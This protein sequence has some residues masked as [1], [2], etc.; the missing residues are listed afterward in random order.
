MNA[1]PV[2]E[3]KRTHH[4]FNTN[5][6]RALTLGLRP[7]CGR[8]VFE[9]DV[10][11]SRGWFRRVLDLTGRYETLRGDNFAFSL[12]SPLP[13]PDGP[14]I[15]AM[16]TVNFYGTQ[17][18]YYPPRMRYDFAFRLRGVGVDCYTQPCDLLLRDFCLEKGR[19]ILLTR[20]SLVQH[21]GMVTTGLTDHRCHRSP[22]FVP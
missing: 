22:T 9:D 6:H 4:R 1:H 15:G 18:V 14:E 19:P 8:F 21:E 3:G 10:S 7:R 5:Y 11:F 16:P 13:L 17:A 2:P 12:Y 20:H